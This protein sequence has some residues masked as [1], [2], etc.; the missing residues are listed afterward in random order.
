VSSFNDDGT[1]DLS[2]GRILVFQGK[3]ESGKS[4]AALWVFRSF[5]LDKLVIDIAHDDGPMGPGVVEISGTAATL[6]PHWP[7]HQRVGKLPMI[8]RYTPEDGSKTFL[9]DIDFV[10]GMAWR[11]STKKKPVMVLIHETNLAVPVG[12]TKPNMRTVLNSNRHR[13]LHVL[14]CQPR[15]KKSD[16]LV[17]AQA[18]LIYTFD[19]P[20]WSDV[21]RTAEVIG[22]NARDLDN[23][24]KRLPP[25]GFL[26]YDAREAKPPP[27]PPDVDVDAWEA[28]HEDWRLVQQAPLP[29][30]VV[31]VTREW[32]MNVPEQ[33][34]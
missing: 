27:P 4:V 20:G 15:A 25:H 7:E 26:R 28:Q 3:K 17:L 13:T 16:P 33:H 10:V 29:A 2:T 14:L 19:M 8:V 12:Q 34:V 32:A 11:H 22:W 5:P 6:S 21:V 23:A 24:I 1:L 30:D 9:E 18:D 31:R